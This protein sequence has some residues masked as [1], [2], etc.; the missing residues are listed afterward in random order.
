MNVVV[1]TGLNH[2][3]VAIFPELPTVEQFVKSL[4]PSL[5]RCL[6]KYTPLFF[7]PDQEF[8][9]GVIRCAKNIFLSEFSHF[10]NH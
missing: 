1:K 6:T 4:P 3:D 8:Y 7:E 2:S 10:Q 5:F 9:F